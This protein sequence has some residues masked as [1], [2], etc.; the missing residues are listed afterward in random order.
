MNEPLVRSLL[1]ASG[2]AILG[3]QRLGAPY[4]TASHLSDLDVESANAGEGSAALASMTGGT[5]G[6]QVY[7][8]EGW[9]SP[10]ALCLTAGTDAFSWGFAHELFEFYNKRFERTPQVD[11]RVNTA[12]KELIVDADGAVVGAVVEDETSRYN[13]NAKKVILACGGITKNPELIAKYA[14]NDVNSI[15]RCC[16]GDTGDAITTCEPLGA[17]VV[18]SHLLG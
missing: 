17:Q 18:G 7:N 1:D 10:T 4:D 11:V 16:G 5:G 8:P 12:A 14:P 15:A 3:L 13:V 9:Y 2:K 6:R